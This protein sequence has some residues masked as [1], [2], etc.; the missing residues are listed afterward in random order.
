MGALVGAPRAIATPVISELMASNNSTITDQD[1]DY[2]DWLELY[3]PDS[4]PD[5]LKGWYLTNKATK[6]TKW[7]IPAVTLA[8][9][10]YLVVF[11]DSKDYTNPAAPLATNFNLSAS[12]GYVALVESDG[13]TVASSYTFPAQYPDVSYGVSQPTSSTEA[14]QVGFFQKATPGAPNGNYTNILLADTAAIASGTQVFAALNNS[15]TDAPT[16]SGTFTGTTS[17][18]LTGAGT[19]EH[20]RY[21]FAPNAVAGSPAGNPIAPPTAAATE[22]TGAITIPS[23]TLLVSAVFSGDDTQRGLPTPAY[24]LQLDSSTSNRVDTFT[25]NL[26]LVIFDDLGYGPIP[27]N[28]VYYNGWTGAYSAAPGATASLTQP[29]DF[30]TP[31][32]MKLHGYTSAS[33]PKQSFDFDLTDT[34]NADLDEP[35]FGMDSAKSWDSIGAWYFDRTQIHNG[36]VYNLTSAMGHWAPRIRYAEMFIHQNGGILDYTDYAGITAITDRIKVDA[37]RVNIYSL[38]TD[39]DTAPNVTGGYILRIDHPETDEFTWTTNGGVPIMLDTPK[40]DVVSPEQSAYIVGYVQQMENAINS[41]QAGGFATRTYP[42]YL[43]FQSWVDY[44]LIN[45]FVENVDA[46]EFSEYFSKDVNGLIVAGP[47]W[48]YDRSMGSADGR[49][50]NPSVWSSTNINYWTYGWWGQLAQDPEFMQAWIDRWETLRGSTFS[51]GNLLGLISTLSGHIGAAAYNRDAARWPDD[52]SRFGSDYTGEID[53]MNSWISTRAAWIDSQFVAQPSAG[54][55]GTS[56]VVTP[57][58]GAVLIY[59]LDG[60]D[61]RAV[62]GAVAAGALTSAS[63]VT[64]PATQAFAARSY[65]ASM[66]HA[67]PGSPWSAPI[68]NPVRLV[69]VSGQAAVGTGA[70]ILVEGFV[71]TG[72]LNSQEQVLLRAVGPGL[73][74]FGVTGVL[75][76]PVLSVFDSTGTLVASNTGW[77]TDQNYPAVANAAT[78]V[79]AFAIAAN[80]ADSALLLNLTPGNYT[81]QVSGAGSSTGNALGEVYEVGQSGSKVINFSSR[82]FVP[83]VGATTT[84]LVITGNAPQQVLVRGDG[85]SLAAFGITNALAQ[86]ILQVFDGT[87]NLVATNTGW[88]TAANAAAIASAASTVGAYAFTAGSAD[89]ALLLTLQPG[90]YTMV[91]TGANGSTGVALAESYVVP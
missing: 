21:V 4:T 79:G 61:P 76:Q 15:G 12:G 3:N 37:D 32:Q 7:P 34:L 87:G 71:V 11:C 66:A 9:G 49:D 77:G 51:T 16:N 67:F 27:D 13:K 36:F 91:I 68:G 35:F 78:T 25:S 80:S 40:L 50:S 56:R 23:T 28:D 73:T 65:A 24:Y 10:A 82:G 84:G 39:D 8:P 26:P 45:V 86:P 14:P 89:S 19:G 53:N 43:D 33:F 64:L 74:Q 75:A 58:A 52:V 44:H 88:S 62:G 63:P 54:L 85:P 55:S 29:A 60:T 6:L 22:Y 46:F 18:T 48:D 17:A 81:M 47:V 38:A 59:T 41:D 2:A 31:A 5:N 69:N 90:S 20:L 57:A 42:S 70:N 72:P 30:F 83:N 1:G